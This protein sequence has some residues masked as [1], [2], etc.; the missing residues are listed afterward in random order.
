MP[1]RRRKATH[2]TFSLL[3]ILIALGLTACG[4]SAPSGFTA[5]SPP[6]ER[7]GL[8]DDAPDRRDGE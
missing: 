4:D 1:D 3:A 6:L 5:G 7:L 2:L 8:L